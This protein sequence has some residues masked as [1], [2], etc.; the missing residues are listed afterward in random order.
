MNDNLVEDELELLKSRK[1][2]AEL[3][4]QKVIDTFEIGT[5]KSLQQIHY[6]IFQDIFPFAGKMREINISKGNFMF[7]PFIFWNKLYKT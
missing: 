2:C 3:W 7:A 1:R 4:D 5:F 6:Y